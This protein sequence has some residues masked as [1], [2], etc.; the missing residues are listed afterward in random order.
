MTMFVAEVLEW[1]K[2]YISQLSP[3]RMIRVR[4][5]EYTFRA[6][7]LEPTI[8]DFRR[9]YQLTV[10]TGFFSFSQR[11]GSPKLM[12]P[13]KGIA[14]WKTKFFYVK[15]VAVVAT[16]IFRNVTETIIA[17]KIVVPRANTVEWF[18]RLRL[19]EWKKM[20]NSQ[21]WVLR[22]MLTRMKRKARPVVQEKS[23]GKYRPSRAVSYFLMFVNE[24]L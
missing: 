2:I 11:Y 16:M 19:I 22:M 8:A 17:E 10:H 18:P 4:H 13:P 6:L 21:L 23:G 9:F 14:K 3:F 24:V 1:Y 15:A 7:S 20:N 12:T 5:F